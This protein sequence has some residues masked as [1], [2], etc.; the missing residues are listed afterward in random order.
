MEEAASLF[1]RLQKIC[2]SQSRHIRGYV[3]RAG[4]P[5]SGGGGA[6]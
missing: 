4:L 2:Q 1:H 5:V 3:R 6:D